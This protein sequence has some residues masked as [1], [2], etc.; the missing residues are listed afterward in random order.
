MVLLVL[1]KKAA[2]IWYKKCLIRLTINLKAILPE[3][4]T[5]AATCLSVPVQ[6]F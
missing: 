3:A 1:C 4:A 2:A 5:T 6:E